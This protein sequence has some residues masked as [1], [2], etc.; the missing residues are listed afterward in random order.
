MSNKGRI[1]IHTFET[2]LWNGATFKEYGVVGH[3]NRG[4]ALSRIDLFV[5]KGGLRILNKRHTKFRNFRC[6]NEKES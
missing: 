2:S 4:I 3:I 5:D 6:I 1:F